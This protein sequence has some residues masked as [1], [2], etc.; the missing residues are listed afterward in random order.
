MGRKP[1]S[2]KVTQAKKAAGIK[3]SKT[4]PRRKR[5]RSLTGEFGAALGNE[6]L[7]GL[8]AELSTVR[9]YPPLTR[10]KDGKYEGDILGF[11]KGLRLAARLT[12]FLRERLSGSAVAVNW[13][14]LLKDGRSC[15]PECDVIVHR[16]GH[17][18]EWNGNAHPI[19]DFKFVEPERAMAVISC[20]SF[21]NAIDRDY[22]KALKKYGVEKIF[23]F[24]ECC[25]RSRLDALRKTAK[26]AG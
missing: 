25:R 11:V 18:R 1:V 16:T 17:I 8:A 3:R 13:G 24:A 20:K 2:K 6:Q 9:S 21:L 12:Y 10:R 26:R 15:S 22:P 7:I 14:H 23:L 5:A 4:L 19:M